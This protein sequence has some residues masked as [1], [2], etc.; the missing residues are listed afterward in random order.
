MTSIKNDEHVLYRILPPSPKGILYYYS[1]DGNTKTKM[2]DLN[3]E[4][5]NG[6]NV[7]APFI[8]NP[9]DVRKLSKK[10]FIARPRQF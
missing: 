1:K 6:F 10:S 4:I 9:H 7:V 3:S 2:I 5:Q 8:A